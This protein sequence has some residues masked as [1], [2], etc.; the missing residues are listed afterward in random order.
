[1]ALLEGEWG[2]PPLTLQTYLDYLESDLCLATRAVDCQKGSR[3]LGSS[4]FSLLKEWN[5]VRSPPTKSNLSF[6]IS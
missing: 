1:M 6:P 5:P 4:F 3:F 2:L